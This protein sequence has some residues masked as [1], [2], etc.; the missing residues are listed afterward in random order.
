MAGAIELP[1][2]F[3]GALPAARGE[4]EEDHRRE[5]LLEPCAG[6]G[7]GP[8]ADHLGPDDAVDREIEVI[9]V[10]FQVVEWI[11]VQRFL[12]KNDARRA[13]KQARELKVAE[14]QAPYRTGNEQPGSR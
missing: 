5:A 7:I 13:A 1:G 9:R 8:T 14:D 4:V 12:A 3:G 2:E 6:G 11:A 10:R